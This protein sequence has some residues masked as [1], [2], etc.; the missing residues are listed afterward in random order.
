MGWRQGYGLRSGS[1]E[2]E[3]GL[4]LTVNNFTIQQWCNSARFLFLISNIFAVQL[5]RCKDREQI[6]V[7]RKEINKSRG[8]G[9]IEN[10]REEKEERG[11]QSNKGQAVGKS[12]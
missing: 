12:Q 1:F 10:K 11:G 5:M 3:K 2:G 7:G 8:K 9:V 6:K 4:V